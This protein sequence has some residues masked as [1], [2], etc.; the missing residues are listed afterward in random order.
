VI[1]ASEIAEAI[2]A[3]Q[4]TVPTLV[5]MDA[6]GM[7]REWRIL[8]AGMSAQQSAA[9][10]LI[11]SRFNFDDVHD[12]QAL[13]VAG[14]IVKPFK[15]EE[16]TERLLDIALRRQ[17]IRA[18]RSAPRF[19]I[20]KD[21]RAEMRLGRAG[22]TELFPLLNISEGGAKVV[23]EAAWQ[24]DPNA[25]PSS[26]SW[27]NVNLEVSIEL[28]HRQKDGVGVRFTKIWEGGPKVLHALEERQARAL[29]ARRKKRKW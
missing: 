6:D 14:V 20:P 3:V 22:K 10:V 26:L 5:V 27:G 16:H 23:A 25:S 8:A 24:P 12:A 11:A 21:A 28:V 2:S 9:I 4:S 15:R 17:N 29:G 19:A 1:E 18:R 7:A 13:R